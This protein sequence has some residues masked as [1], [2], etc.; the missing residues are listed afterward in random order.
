MMSAGHHL[1]VGTAS[2][3][4]MYNLVAVTAAVQVPATDDAARHPGRRVQGRLNGFRF[5]RHTVWTA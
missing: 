1:Y 2:P 3:I 5:H 4:T